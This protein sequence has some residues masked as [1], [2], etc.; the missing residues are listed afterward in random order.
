[1]SCRNIVLATLLTAMISHQA[2]GAD[3]PIRESLEKAKAVYEKELDQ[4]QTLAK[5]FFE[6]REGDAREK[7]N[8]KQVGEIK[9]LR[10][11]FDENGELPSYAPATLRQR[12]ASALSVLSLEYT[13]AIETYTRTKQD[14]SAAAAKKELAEIKAKA[15]FPSI[16]GTWEE[17]EG[18][19]VVI[20]QNGNKFKAGCSYQH[21]EAG[22]VSW[23]MNGTISKDGEIKGELIHTKPKGFR[24][25]TRTGIYSAAESKI[26]GNAEWK[27]GQSG[28]E[29]RLVE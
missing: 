13:K 20:S 22:Q 12:P 18:I 15:G 1:M 29:W 5:E 10:E 28:F 17:S 14:A 19:R 7:G 16:E 8:L 2:L 6:K 11:R 4:Y 27:G 25:Q 23:M 21:A 24:N 3:D 9:A 26:T